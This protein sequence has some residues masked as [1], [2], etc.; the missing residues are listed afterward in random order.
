MS[1]EQTARIDLALA[2]LTAKQHERG[3]RANLDRLRIAFGELAVDLKQVTEK[4]DTDRRGS[5]LKAVTAVW[6]FLDKLDPHDENDLK[7]TFATLVGA[8]QGL[9]NGTVDP[10][11]RPAKKCGRAPDPIDIALVRAVSAAWMGFLMKAGKLEEDA[12]EAVARA[13]IQQGVWPGQQRNVGI[14][15]AGWTIKKWRDRLGEGG[16]QPKA[17]K[18]YKS[19]RA[20]YQYPLGTPADS[21]QAELPIILS[22]VLT[23]RRFRAKSD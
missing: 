19:L 7:P 20:K 2:S 13:L 11:L 6:Q 17:V 1:Q 18:L 5:W 9:N 23:G 22:K 14:K 10:G 4:L 15:Q 8:L 21:I 3:P 12:G 16:D